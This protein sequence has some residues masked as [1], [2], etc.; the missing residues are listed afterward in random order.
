MLLLCLQKLLRCELPFNHTTL[1][2]AA[3]GFI[4]LIY[5]L[6]LI[7][8]GLQICVFLYHCSFYGQTSVLE[9]NGSENMF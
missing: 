3:A 6:L 5:V 8:C 2:S 9:L 7:V 1:L 4:V